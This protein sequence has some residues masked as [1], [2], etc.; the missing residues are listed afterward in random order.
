MSAQPQQTPAMRH[1]ARITIS[2]GRSRTETQWRAQEVLWSELLERLRTPKRTEE[3]L[4]AFG[5]MR[6]SEQDALKDVGGFVGGTLKSGRRM[7][8]NV[9]W[10]QVLT[11]DA[12]FGRTDLLSD[13]SM[14][15]WAWALY[16][17][18][19]HGL[20]PGVLRARVLI[21]LSRPVTPDEYQ[22]V[23][24]RI[25]ADLGLEQFDDTTHEPARL[26]Y[27]PSCSSDSEYMF[28]HQDSAWLD[29]NTILAR[30]DD[31]RDQTQW[32][33]SD[34][35][36]RE[37]KRRSTRAGDPETKPGEIGL[38]CRTWSIEEAIAEHLADVYTP[39]RLPDLVP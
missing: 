23:S 1:D 21:P 10:R 36:E 26:M 19:K 12:D 30:Y 9:A 29:P 4:A 17:T 24:R 27:W 35:F 25:A 33:T 38:F 28:E 16:S 22:A 37:V 2:V 13:L 34:A 14:K 15:P 7:A 18:R 20:T 6:K 39:T 8:I 32:P 11:L 31:W 5:A 3:T